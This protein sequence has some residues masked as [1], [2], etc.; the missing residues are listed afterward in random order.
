MSDERQ[1]LQATVSDDPLADLPVGAS[2]A[3]A[4]V[5]FGGSDAQATPDGVTN[6]DYFNGALLGVVLR[7]QA[8]GEL[9]VVGSGVMIAPGLAVTA[10]HNFR[11]EIPEITTGANDLLCFGVRSSGLD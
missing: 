3:L 9:R 2:L 11:E 5:I 6:W 10:T 8:T 4:P 1:S 7:M